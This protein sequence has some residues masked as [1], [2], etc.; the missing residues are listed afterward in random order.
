MCFSTGT[1]L[2][3]WTTELGGKLTRCPKCLG[4]GWI[5][6]P[7]SDPRALRPRAEKQKQPPEDLLDGLDLDL[8]MDMREARSPAPKTPSAFPRTGLYQGSPPR[9]P[10]PPT[11]PPS[12]SEKGGR[13]IGWTIALTVLAFVLAGAGYVAYAEYANGAERT[14][15]VSL[16]Y[17]TPSPTYAPAYTSTPVPPSSEPR[18]THLA[19]LS[20]TAATP[21]PRPRPAN[22]APIGYPGHCNAVAAAFWPS[23][24]VAG[25]SPT[26]ALANRNPDQHRD[27][28]SRYTH[29][30]T[31]LHAGLHSNTD[32]HPGPPRPAPL[33]PPTWTPTATPTPEPTPHP[34]PHLRHMELKVQMLTLINRARAAEGI[35][36]VDL[37]ENDAAQ[38]HAEDAI[39]NCFSSHWG[40]DGLKPYM[41]YSVH[42]GYQSNGE[43]GLG[44]NYCYTAADNVRWVLPK[45]GVRQAMEGLMNSPGHRSNILNTWHRKVN[46][47]IAFDRYRLQVAQHFEGDYVEYDELPTL[48]DGVLTL[49]GWL[50]NGATLA[51]FALGVQ[52]YYDPPPHA[53]TRGQLSRTYCYDYGDKV[54]GL[55]KPLT[56]GSN[57]TADTFTTPP[58][59]CPDPYN[60]PSEAP[61]P[62]SGAESHEHWKAAK[63]ASQQTPTGTQTVPWVIAQEWEVSLPRFRVVADLG[64][65]AEKPG[66]YTVMVWA[67]LGGERTVVSVYSV[68]KDE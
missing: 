15:L 24:P 7:A 9:R 12:P 60:V 51:A 64:E 57:Y 52:V 21:T 29:T 65:L 27:S 4:K 56:P 2:S 31:D 6:E 25:I 19:S 33:P 43:N 66:V 68:F 1:V 11:D 3:R 37:G 47:G 67:E 13:G 63:E 62:N 17:F 41:R 35:G 22:P 18:R 50:K 26:E 55:L 28:D 44:G 59:V 34:T 45:E 14:P 58:S 30:R 38:L 42:G 10:I 53:L 48:R 36:P 46:I 23:V 8:F 49:R 61:A 40:T 5:Q 54:A 39:E 16:L 20:Q 32:A